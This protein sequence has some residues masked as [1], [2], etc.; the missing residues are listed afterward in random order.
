M[1]LDQFARATGATL[2]RAQL[3]LEPFVAV[4]A[5]H[6]IST[7]QR[8]SAFLAQIGHESGGLR[9]VEESLNYT[10]EAILKTFNTLQVTRFS[11]EQ[12]RLY[13][14]NGGKQ[15][16]QNMIASIAYANRMGNGPPESMD[17]WVYRGRGPIQLTGKNAYRRCGDALGINLVSRPDLLLD[18]SYGAQAAAW[19][20]SEGNST[21]KS[22]NL[23]ADAGNYER[24][25][26]IING[27]TNG[28]HERLE[29]TANNLATLA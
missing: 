4:M 16:S 7:R 6:D 27:G 28:M 14:R 13:G 29:M 2:A 18:P 17:G 10:P 26:K 19:F 8:K 3:W 20:W 25:G 9:M 15:A 5:L 11:V 22:L 21:G 1:T 23:L 24:I 12:A